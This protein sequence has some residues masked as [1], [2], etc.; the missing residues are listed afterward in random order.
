MRS[1]LQTVMERHIKVRAEAHPYHPDW[2]EYFR[3]RRA[4]AWR[5]YP[6][7]TLAASLGRGRKRFVDC[8]ASRKGL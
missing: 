4:F 7:G 6:V 5:S 3:K 8:F 1:L 2:I